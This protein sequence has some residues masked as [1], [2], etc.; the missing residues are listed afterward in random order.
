[1]TQ[2]ESEAVLSAMK[3]KTDEQITAIHQVY[4]TNRMKLMSDQARSLERLHQAIKDIQI[5]LVYA[6]DEQFKARKKES[7]KEKALNVKQISSDLSRLY[8][9]VRDINTYYK[10]E[11][12]S[13]LEKR[14]NE[15]RKLRN[16][17]R[18]E[19]ERI[20]A[21]VEYPDREDQ[22]K[23]WRYKYHQ[24]KEETDKLRAEIKKLKTDAA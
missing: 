11:F 10:L 15:L 20:M 1:M 17:Y 8:N 14:D 3:R 2:Q 5:K 21:K 19:K 18:L 22:V 16:E 12:R 9:E 6:K 7:W 24:Q 13:N 4:D 23:Y